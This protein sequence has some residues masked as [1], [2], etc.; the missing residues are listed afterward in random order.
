M[1][2]RNGFV[3]SDAAAGRFPPWPPRLIAAITGRRREWRRAASRDP[4]VDA[5]RAW[6]R[7]LLRIHTDSACGL[8]LGRPGE[9]RWVAILPDPSG[10]PG[11]FKV[12]PFDAAGIGPHA[13]GYA[14]ARA[15]LWAA[16]AAGYTE[17]APGMFTRLADSTGWRARYRP[18]HE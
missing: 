16:L 13:G 8:E 3:S 12:Q 4:A 6:R 5:V 14:T 1:I 10:V 9:E 15:A 18:P 17:P 2:N 7:A 11:T